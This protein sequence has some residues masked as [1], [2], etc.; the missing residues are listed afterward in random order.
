ML[1]K[2]IELKKTIINW[3]FAN[4]DV[5]QRTNACIEYFRPYIY[6]VDGNFLIDGEEIIDFIIEADKLIYG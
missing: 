1:E 3:L 2:T 5:W 4:K 6:N